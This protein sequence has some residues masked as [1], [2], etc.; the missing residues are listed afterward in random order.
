MTSGSKG[1]HLYAHLDGSLSAA[2]ASDL[3]RELA[4][5]LQS[6]HP[7][8]VTSVMRKSDRGGK[9]FLDWSQNNGNK[10]TITPYSLRG[11]TRPTVAAPR[12]WDELADPGLQQVELG[13]MLTRL[14]D[15]GDLLADLDP[16]ALRDASRVLR[17]SAEPARPSVAR[18][19]HEPPRD[20][21][22]RSLRSVRERSDRR[23]QNGP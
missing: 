18:A 22:K 3:A 13:E 9:V 8:R 14:K 21:A 2:A 5:A 6:E 1:I 12:T 15:L 10:T 11:R 7:D 23:H 20:R 4:Q 19:T 16:P 17:S